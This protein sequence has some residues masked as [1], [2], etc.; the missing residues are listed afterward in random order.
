MQDRTPRAEE[1]EPIERAGIDELRD[2]QRERLRWSLRHAY[3]NV[4]HYRRAFDAAGVHPD[5]CRD[6]D[7]LAR[8]PFTGKAELRE[9]Y[10]FGMFAV[11]GSGCPGC[12]PPPAPPADRRWSATPAMT[13]APGRD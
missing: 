1:L 7:D 13:C 6:L 5:D 9:N 8:F 4:P 12:T 11:P 10:P 3:D 2:L